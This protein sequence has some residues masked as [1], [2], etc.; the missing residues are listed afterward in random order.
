M[1]YDVALKKPPFGNPLAREL[2][3]LRTYL[4][5]LLLWEYEWEPNPEDPF[6]QTICRYYY[7]VILA[8]VDGDPKFDNLVKAGG[9]I[10]SGAYLRR[11]S[12]PD[13]LTGGLEMLSPSCVFRDIEEFIRFKQLSGGGP[14]HLPLTGLNSHLAST[15]P[16]AEL[17]LEVRPLQSSHSKKPREILVLSDSQ[18]DTDG[19]ISYPVV[20]PVTHTDQALYVRWL[21]DSVRGIPLRNVLQLDGTVI[22]ANDRMGEA[23]YQLSDD[24][25]EF[26]LSL[27]AVQTG[28]WPSR[29]NRPIVNKLAFFDQTNPTLLQQILTVLPIQF[30]EPLPKAW[31]AYRL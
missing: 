11:C 29:L 6:W 31:M 24:L 25:E 5:H 10:A 13:G 21:Q 23:L 30:M 15:S 9:R 28:L 18:F 3:E 4:D 16:D 1:K 26:Y 14:A 8:Q 19:S 17:R 27:H 2:V 7:L 12:Y 20:A 22:N